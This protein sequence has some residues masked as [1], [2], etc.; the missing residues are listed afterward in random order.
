MVDIVSVFQVTNISP[1]QRGSELRARLLHPE[2]WVNLKLHGVGL[3]ASC[4]TLTAWLIPPPLLLLLPSQ[5]SR[6]HAVKETSSERTGVARESK[7]QISLWSIF[8]VRLTHK[9]AKLLSKTVPGK[10]V[11]LQCYAPN[12]W[13]P[14]YRSWNVLENHS[15]AALSTANVHSFTHHTVYSA[16][17]GH[18]IMV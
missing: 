7:L 15:V 1:N 3:L 9:A 13:F 14:N 17:I 2:L 11:H 5:F 4:L 16:L 12:T 10:T 6:G 18:Y 8:L